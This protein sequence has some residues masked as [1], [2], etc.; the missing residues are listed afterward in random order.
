LNLSQWTWE[1]SVA[2]LRQQ[3]DQKAL[4]RAC[5]YD[6]PLLGAAQRFARSDEW[7][8]LRTFLPRPAGLALDIGAGRGISSYALAANGWQVVALE[9]DPGSLV[10]SGAILELARE[11]SLP[12][13]VEEAFGEAMPFDDHTF[14][15][16]YGRE[17]LHHAR[18]LTR[19]CLEA[20]RVLKPGGRLLVTRETVI[21]RPEDLAVFL[22]NHPLHKYFGGENAFLLERY[23]SALTDSG[24]IINK[25]LGPLDS[26][27]NLYPFDDELAGISYRKRNYRRIRHLLAR[28]L[29]GARSTLAHL[30]PR[31]V[32]HRYFQVLDAPGRLF[33]FIAQKPA[34]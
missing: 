1:E 31:S 7:R 22:N 17:V 4:V 16:V 34:G 28:S 3:P 11:T 9:P 25:I 32:A 12:I 6:D 15:L 26:S 5:Y 8:A 14:D 33:S 27:I 21:S 18:D 13:R 10:G 24:L 29:Y 20:A 19:L 30:L 23:I 2:W